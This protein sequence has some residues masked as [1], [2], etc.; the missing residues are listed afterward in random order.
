MKISVDFS[1]MRSKLVRVVESAADFSGKMAAERLMQA[2]ILATPI[3][4]GYARSQWTYERRPNPALSRRVSTSTA[5]GINE[6]RY[7]I[8]N[9]A[10]YIIYLNRGSSK[11][12]PAFFVEKTILEQGFKLRR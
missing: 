8:S 3:K 7:T 6:A 11:Q 9:Y 5:F 2:M 12:A 1:R 10:P 4:T